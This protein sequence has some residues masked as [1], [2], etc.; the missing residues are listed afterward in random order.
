M[1]LS[2]SE[3]SGIKA[4]AKLAFGEDAK[5]YLFGSRVHDHLKGGD[6]DLYIEVR[7]QE[8]TLP[9]KLRMLR[10]LEKSLG[11]RKIDIIVNNFRFEKPIYNIARSEGIQL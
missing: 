1:R 11:E 7:D 2:Q 3:I 8:N 9:R 5:V 4:A 6:I 10:L